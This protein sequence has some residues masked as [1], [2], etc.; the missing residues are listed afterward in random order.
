MIIRYQT[1]KLLKGCN[2]KALA[3]RRWGPECGTLIML[4]LAQIKA[5]DNLAML[6]MI[7][8]MRCHELKGDRKGRISVDVMHP[9]RLISVPCQNP[10]PR[11][12]DGGLDWNKVTELM[13]TAVE[14]T[15]D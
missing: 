9:L 4:R 5:A 11:K 6:R 14:D 7:P 1:A 15:H 8:Q 12:P 3:V 10:V 2:D 13:V